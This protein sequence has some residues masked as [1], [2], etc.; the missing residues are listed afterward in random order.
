MQE[1][2][3]AGFKMRIFVDSSTLIALARIG[4][5]DMLRILFKEIFITAAIKKEILKEES[6]DAEAFKEAIHL[7]IRVIEHKDNPNA[8]RKY[9]LDSGETSLFLAAKQHDRLILDEANARRFAESKGLKFTGLIGL[10]VAA[11]RAG[12]LTKEE[13]LE[14]INKLAAG[15]FR[16]SLELYLWAKEEI[17]RCC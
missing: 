15:D 16:M 2:H 12:K 6:P 14:I 7:W 11:V 17:E 1:R 9:G 5:L 3:R 13:A 4:K 10:I 8:F